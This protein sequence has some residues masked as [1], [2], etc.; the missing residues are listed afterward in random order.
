MPFHVQAV[1][2]FDENQIIVA[3]NRA[4]EDGRSLNL[5]EVDFF[6]EQVWIRETVVAEEMGKPQGKHYSNDTAAHRLKIDLAAKII[7]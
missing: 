3:M 4:F 6:H 1:A 2:V 7:N 5:G